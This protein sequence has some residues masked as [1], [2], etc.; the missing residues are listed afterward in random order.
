MR[1]KIVF[2]TLMA[3]S[4]LLVP[5]VFSIVD[6]QDAT[7]SFAPSASKLHSIKKISETDLKAIYHLATSKG[8]LP[9]ISNPKFITM[10]TGSNSASIIGVCFPSEDTPTYVLKKLRYHSSYEREGS[11]KEAYGLLALMN[12]PMFM[13]WNA[14]QNLQG[15]ITLLVNIPLALYMKDDD[16][17]PQFTVLLKAAPGKPFS[18]CKLDEPLLSGFAERLA[19]LHYDTRSCH[20]DLNFSN[21][22]YDALTR[23]ITLIDVVG[24]ATPVPVGQELEYTLGAVP[25]SDSWIEGDVQRVCRQLSGPEMF[26]RSEEIFK[27]SYAHAMIRRDN[28]K[29]NDVRKKF[30]EMWQALLGPFKLPHLK[31]PFEPS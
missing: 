1:K 18:Q 28:Q 6:P 8:D 10:P 13:E 4:V 17:F 26:S 23:T 19:E 25:Y 15:G 7:S 27:K 3:L 14:K 22:F 20:R 31:N 30:G 11:E 5:D 21:I 2:L 12:N 16:D 9:P 24:L 29:G